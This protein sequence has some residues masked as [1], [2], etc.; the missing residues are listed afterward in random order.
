M[1]KTSRSKSLLNH[2]SPD[3]FDSFTDSF[4]ITL[5][6][7]AMD[8][9]A[10]S[11]PMKEILKHINP[12]EIK[13]IFFKEEMFL[14]SKPSTWP[15]VDVLISFYSE[16]FPISKVQKYS[17]L[18][19]PMLINDI[20]KQELLWD[21]SLIYK[22]LKKAGIPTPNHFFVYG[23]RHEDLISKYKYNVIFA[24]ERGN[25]NKKRSFDKNG[26]IQN[27][28]NKCHEEMKKSR[29][30]SHCGD[31]P[32]NHK[33]SKGFEWDMSKSNSNLEKKRTLTPCLFLKIF[34]TLNH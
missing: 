7:C 20:N 25:K 24:N 13:I 31:N 32:K 3:H 4:P 33:N 12:E 18:R 10:Q 8:K 5:G 28:L 22:E 2:P 29:K 30:G 1:H 15:V 34:R 19:K 21:R 9:K 14:K 6:I 23:D 26:N 17:L 27:F 11:S 16:G